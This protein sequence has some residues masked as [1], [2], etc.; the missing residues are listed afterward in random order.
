[1]VPKRRPILYELIRLMIRIEKID[2][3]APGSW[4]LVLHVD[5]SHRPFHCAELVRNLPLYWI[6]LHAHRS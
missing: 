2:S 6:A 1:M 3:H 4:Y 5:S